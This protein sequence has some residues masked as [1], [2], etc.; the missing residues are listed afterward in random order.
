[1]SHDKNFALASLR[2]RTFQRKERAP[3]QAIHDEAQQGSVVRVDSLRNVLR[4]EDWRAARREDFHYRYS[5]YSTGRRDFKTREG[6][7]HS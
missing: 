7:R 6:R 2:R 1:M 3:G 4:V 5:R